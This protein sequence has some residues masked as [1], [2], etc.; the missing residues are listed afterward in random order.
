MKERCERALEI[1]W[2]ARRAEGPDAPEVAEARRHL[3]ACPPCRAYLRRDEV[4]AARLREIRL[5]NVTPCPESVRS[6][7]ARELTNEDAVLAAI[8]SSAAAAAE[9]AQSD[10]HEGLVDTLKN[11]LIDRLQGRRHLWPPWI[12][13]A[14]AAVAAAVLITG[15]LALSQRL[16]AGLPDEAFVEDFQRTALPEIVRQ[17]VAPK[18]VQAFH[19]AHFGTEGPTIMLDMP[20]TRVA[21]CKLD[22]RMGTMVEYDW[23]GDRLVFYQVPLD[24][25]GP[26]GE[27]RA[28]REGELNMARWADAEY[29][30]ALVSSMPGEDLMELAKRARAART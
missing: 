3:A 13:G 2:E 23:S 17:P 22:G 9:A 8:E 28:T 19:E 1:V 21:L 5:S 10:P 4:L 15:G 20:V 26:N 16:E 27:M 24:G 11:N 29:D 7:V 18:D 30:Y 12:E 6:K 14:V 25:D